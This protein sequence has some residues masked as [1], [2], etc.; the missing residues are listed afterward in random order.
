M[1]MALTQAIQHQIREGGVD[2]MQTFDLETL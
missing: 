1:I 2:A